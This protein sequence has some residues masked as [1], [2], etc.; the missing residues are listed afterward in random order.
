MSN[1]NHSTKQ[2]Y[3]EEYLYHYEASGMSKA[4]YCRENNLVY[5]QFVW[6]HKRLCSQLK[7]GAEPFVALQ[8]KL[9][10]PTHRESGIV[11]E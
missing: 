1:H 3:W 8:H 11:I 4:A 10:I 2:Q 5:H 6:W 7:E 9:V